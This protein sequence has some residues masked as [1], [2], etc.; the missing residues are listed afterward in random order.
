MRSSVRLGRTTLRA[1]L[2]GAGVAVLVAAS[3]CGGSSKPAYCSDRAQ[4]QKSVDDLKGIVGSSGLSG[5]QLQLSTVRRNATT[6]AEDAKSDFPTETSALKSSVDAL[7]A[8]V[9]ALPASPST[10]Q[11]TAVAL[12]VSAVVSNAKT[13]SKATTS[14]CD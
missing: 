9:K 4:L 8:A 13:L 6:L 12:D 3:G 11:V 7:T 1:L 2:A 5:L 10:V 14:A